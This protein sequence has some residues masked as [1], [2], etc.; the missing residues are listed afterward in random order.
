MAFQM[1]GQPQQ[2]MTPE[3]ISRQRQIA[4]ALLQQGMDT[5]PVQHWSQGAARIAQALL[6]G[7]QNSQANA[8]DAALQR[9]KE[10]DAATEKAKA[11]A[12]KRNTPEFRF[13]PDGSLYNWNPFMAVGGKPLLLSQATQKKDELTAYQ[14]ERLRLAERDQQLREQRL[15]KPG[16]IPNAV[17]TKTAEAEVAASQIEAQLDAYKDLVA[18]AADANGVRTGGTGNAVIGQQADAV[19]TARVG[20]QM[21]M[22]DAYELGAITGPDMQILNDMLVDP[23]VNMGGAINPFAEGRGPFGAVAGEIGSALRLGT[24]IRERV[25]ANVDQVKAEFKRRVALRRKSLER[26]FGGQMQSGTEPP[27]TPDGSALTPEINT[28][29]ELQQQLQEGQTATDTETGKRYT[30]RNGQIVEVQ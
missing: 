24:G 2:A 30:K 1:F 17:R 14:K 25:A 26:E 13:G 28:L 20:L 18:G 6:G 23:T 3:G 11:E 15:G 4:Q 21:A 10:L 8:A 22:K 9:K 7:Y 16:A 5:S 12:E 19:K 29:D 27:P